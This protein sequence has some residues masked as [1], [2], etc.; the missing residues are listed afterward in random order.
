M[1]PSFF[2]PSMYYVVRQELRII[3]MKES[4][5]QQLL[6]GQTS[7]ARKIFDAVPIAEPWTEA[8]INKTF[9]LTG[10]QPVASHT[11]RACLRDM[12]DAG[13]IRE[14]KVGYYQRVAVTRNVPTPQKEVEPMS[15]QSAPARAPVR[16]TVVTHK[17]DL[18]ITN[19]DEVAKPKATAATV[20]LALAI[21]VNELH[22]SFSKGI[23]NI[24]EQLEA[25]ATQ[26]E[27]ESAANAEAAE[28]LARLRALLKGI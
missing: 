21:Q 8:T 5:Q 12:R 18:A 28:N 25:V 26:V 13:L 20:L 2:T 9:S 11:L 27:E 23:A 22:A 19:A 6:Q 1:T 24:A 16:E 3:G 14:P 4:R 10:A 17:I 7:Q 15:S